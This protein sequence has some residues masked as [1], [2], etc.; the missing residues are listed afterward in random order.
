MKRT[1][2]GV[3]ALSSILVGC[4]GGNPS[5]YRWGEFPQQTYMYMSKQ[6]KTSPLE[7]IA[8]LEKDIEIAKSENKAVPPGLYAHLG[9]LN[10]DIQNSQR[11]AMYFELEKQVYPESTVLM[12]RL[13]KGLTSQSQSGVK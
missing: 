4:G 6:G 2:L 1:L 8:R 9:L 10:I 3:L 12:N 5:L 7:Q 11:A 13:L